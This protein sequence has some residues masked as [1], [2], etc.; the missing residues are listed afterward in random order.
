M[1]TT[2]E[3]TS[4]QTFVEIAKMH[5]EDRPFRD[6][7]QIIDLMKQLSKECIDMD[8]SGDAKYKYSANIAIIGALA[9]ATQHAIDEDVF[10]CV[11][12]AGAFIG[13][14][15]RRQHPIQSP[16]KKPLII[17]STRLH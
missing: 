16:N 14:E 7:K 9:W 2:E 17:Q 5:P 8:K 12:G 6:K 13:D 3:K 1:E 15:I 10:D 4:E 11:L